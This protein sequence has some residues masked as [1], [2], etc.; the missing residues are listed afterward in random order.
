[1]AITGQCE[2]PISGNFTKDDC[3]R[4]H[5]G[6]FSLAWSV[7]GAICEQCKDT[8]SVD[9]EYRW[10]GLQ[11][12]PCGDRQ[13]NKS[14]VNYIHVRPPEDYIEGSASAWLGIIGM[15]LCNRA[16]KSLSVCLGSLREIFCSRA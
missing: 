12:C 16:S 1:V 5:V 2:S 13:T 7:D 15:G 3:C 6:R 14:Q 4:G 8:Y 11:S 9:S 10:C